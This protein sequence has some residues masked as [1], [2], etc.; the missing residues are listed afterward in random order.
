MRIKIHYGLDIFCYEHIFWTPMLMDLLN[1]SLRHVFQQIP[2]SV[3][4]Y[5]TDRVAF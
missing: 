3:A 4:S 1:T 2:T 5:T